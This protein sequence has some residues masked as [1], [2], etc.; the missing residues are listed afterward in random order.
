MPGKAVMIQSVGIEIVESP[1][2][3]LARVVIPTRL[4]F[5]SNNPPPLDPSAVDVSVKMYSS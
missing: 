2:F 5:S 1:C 3:V 4:A